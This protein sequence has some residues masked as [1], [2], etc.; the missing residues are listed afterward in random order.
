MKSIQKYIF[1]NLFDT[2]V[3][4]KTNRLFNDDDIEEELDFLYKILDN[5]IK[6]SKRNW[7]EFV[8]RFKEK[9]DQ[10]DYEYDNENQGMFI[11]TQYS[12][13]TTGVCIRFLTNTPRKS[14]DIKDSSHC[15]DFMYI[16]SERSV[17]IK[18]YTVASA[19]E[20]AKVWVESEQEK[21]TRGKYR[22]SEKTIKK[23]FSY[24]KE[25]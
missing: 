20:V 11:D 14:R 9:L 12:K 18:Q 8:N 16:P 15:M 22:I 5:Q 23:I 25:N 3:V 10:L 19:Q 7:F 1:E 4:N 6:V 13:N 2:E 24:W 21:N 17:V